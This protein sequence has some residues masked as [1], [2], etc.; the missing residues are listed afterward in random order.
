MNLAKRLAGNRT[1]V[2]TMFYCSPPPPI[3]EQK[4]PASFEKQGRYLSEV[5]KIAG[6]EIRYA[7]LIKQADGNYHEK[8][9]DTQMTTDMLMMAFR[10]EYDV[11][12]IVS[13]DGDFADAVKN[14]RELAKRTEVGFFRGSLSFN[15]R[16]SADLARKL[17]PIFFVDLFHETEQPSLFD[18]EKTENNE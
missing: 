3:L 17:R 12:I 5:S 13:N 7:N 11:A 9:L 18:I 4:K 15:L 8:N 6:V 16:Q 2:K 14:V 1:L 10:N